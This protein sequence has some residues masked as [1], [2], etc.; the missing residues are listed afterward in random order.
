MSKIKSE[1][2]GMSGG[3]PFLPY[4][5]AAGMV[6]RRSPPGIMPATPTSQPLI[7]SPFPSL[8]EKGLPFLF[9]GKN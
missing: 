7:T 6:R 2:P 9:A 5:S 3:A 8:K 1:F 4:A